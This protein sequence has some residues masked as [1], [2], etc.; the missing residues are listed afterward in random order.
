M[1]ISYFNRLESMAT[2]P[3]PSRQEVEFLLKLIDFVETYSV[4]HFKHE[5]G[6]MPRHQCP[7]H[8]ENKNAHE[9]FLALFRQFKLR[10]E[11]EGCRPELVH[12]LQEPAQTGFSNTSSSGPAAQN[13]PA[14]GPA[15]GDLPQP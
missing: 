8:A 6:C 5:E 13:V 9:Q 12:E 1:L 11:A 14:S 10:L 4:V 3:Y 2:N 7:A 15:C